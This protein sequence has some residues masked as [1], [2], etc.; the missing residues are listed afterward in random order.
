M[1]VFNFEYLFIFVGNVDG[2]FFKYFGIDLCNEYMYKVFNL[3][4]FNFDGGEGYEDNCINCYW[5]V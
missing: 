2:M 4:F 3:G 5:R 1:K